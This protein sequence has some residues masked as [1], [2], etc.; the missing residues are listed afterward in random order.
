MEEK[1]VVTEVPQ[2]VVKKSDIIEASDKRQPLKTVLHHV[3]I[4]EGADREILPETFAGTVERVG[5][6]SPYCCS[7]SLCCFFVDRRG[8]CIHQ[9]SPGS[10][11]GTGH[12]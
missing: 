2:E 7:Y 3:G 6:Y 12:H 1:V 8:S 5:S 11:R 10:S 4:S 9:S